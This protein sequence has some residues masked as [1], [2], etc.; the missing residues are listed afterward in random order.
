MF[1]EFAETVSEP[2]ER[3]QNQGAAELADK[4]IIMYK[5]KIVEQ[6]PTEVI[7]RNPQQIY[8]QK[9]IASLPKIKI[10]D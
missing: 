5:G 7:L 1:Q 6:G 9:L 4:V 3:L 8:T 2:Y 10:E